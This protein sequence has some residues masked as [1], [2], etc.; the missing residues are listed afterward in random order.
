VDAGCWRIHS[1][2]IEIHQCPLPEGC[3]GGI[4]FTESTDTLLK[5]VG[6]CKD[7]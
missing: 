6:Y 2:S 7:G 4:N 1:T 5:A 3:V